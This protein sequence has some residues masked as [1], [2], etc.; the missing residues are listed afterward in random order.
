MATMPCSI[1][2]RSIKCARSSQW[3]ASC[4]PRALGTAPSA[5]SDAPDANHDGLSC[6]YHPSEYCTELSEH[7]SET[8]PSSTVTASGRHG[9]ASNVAPM[10]IHSFCRPPS[11]QRS[12]RTEPRKSELQTWICVVIMA[13]T[14]FGAALEQRIGVGSAGRRAYKIPPRNMSKIQQLLYHVVQR[15]ARPLCCPSPER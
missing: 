15:P 1:Y 8:Q 12:P 2:V 11:A 7:S 6:T 4:R 10:H 13:L 5:K 3:P 14:S 9:A